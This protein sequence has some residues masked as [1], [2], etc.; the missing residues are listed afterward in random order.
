MPEIFLLSAMSGREDIGQLKQYKKVGFH[1]YRNTTLQ[2][3]QKSCS[4]VFYV[5]K[6]ERKCT[7]C[8][9]LKNHERK[10]KHSIAPLKYLDDLRGVDDDASYCNKLETFAVGTR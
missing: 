8:L 7:L 1:S 5:F 3:H 2:Q 4:S 6:R 10:P 9:Q